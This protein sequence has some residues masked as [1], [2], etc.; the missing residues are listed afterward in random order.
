MPALDAS[1]LPDK[2]RLRWYSHPYNRA[3]F[4]RMAGA[5]GWLPRGSRL[6]L[7]R[8]L[9]WLAPRWFPA[10]RAAVRKALARMTG[11]SDGRLDELTVGLFRNFAMCFSDLVSTNREPA[12]QLARHVSR[13]SGSEQCAEP[14]RGLVFL[15][16]HIGN[17]ELAGRLLAGRIARP[18]HVVVTEDEAQELERW[19]RRNGDGVH[20]VPRSRPTVS[21]QLIA[22]LRRGDI[23]A[24]QGDRALGG[25]GDLLTPFFGE[26]APFPMGPFRLASAADV[27]V[28]PAF[29]L[30]GADYRYTVTV[31]EP[32]TVQPGREAAGVRAWVAGLERV[33]REH[34]TQWF[35]FF[36]PWE[37]LAR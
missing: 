36:D 4:Y 26:P 5:L 16:A 13:V 3:V 19:V 14:G 28:V 12:A 1:A 2:A 22:A 32:L 15:T 25:R 6:A 7:A 23:V 21:I 17:W 8:Q 31:L 34:P 10:E 30:L 9:G 37:P 33:V 20:F 18:T 24:M 35:N 27:P 29:C 11:D